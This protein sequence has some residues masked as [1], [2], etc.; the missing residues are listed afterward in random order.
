[1]IV[2][3]GGADEGRA[4]FMNLHCFMGYGDDGVMTKPDGWRIV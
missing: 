1:M 3:R 2:S 4:M